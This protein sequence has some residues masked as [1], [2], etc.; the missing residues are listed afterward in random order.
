[1]IENTL[2]GSAQNFVGDYIYPGIIYT[3]LLLLV[4]VY[5]SF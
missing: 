2:I 3:L 5:L 4:C 1:M